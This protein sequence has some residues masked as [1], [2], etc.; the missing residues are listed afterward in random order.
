MHILRTRFAKDIVAE[1]LPPARPTKKQRVVIIC[2][3][4]PSTPSKKSLIEFFSKK[5]F[6]AIHFRYRG[7]WESDGLFLKMSP[8]QDLIDV[9]EALPKGFKDAWSQKTFKLK[10]DQIIVVSSSFGGAAGILASNHPSI[11]KVIAIS[12]MLDWQKPG[13]DEPY[14]KMIRFFEEG[15]GQGFRF[16][17]NGWDK[18]KSGKFF[19]PVREV[20][21]IDGSK[22]LL[23]HAKDDKTC[24]YKITKKFSTDT[25]SRLI[26]LEKG[27]HLSG[28]IIAMPRFYKLFQNFI[29]N[30]K[31]K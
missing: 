16:A 22:L 24:P 11:H 7:S 23:I 21:N 29:K 17:K 6:W 3:G 31:V 1:F 13:P 5:G 25:S 18:L 28:S 12:P 15:Y 19:N 9:V 27:D 2:S 26:T 8:H 30:G 14:P 4:A 20:A 10:P